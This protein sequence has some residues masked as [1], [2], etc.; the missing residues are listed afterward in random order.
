MSL[1][2]AIAETLETEELRAALPDADADERLLIE[3]VLADRSLDVELDEDGDVIEPVPR[4]NA[5]S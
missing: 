2:L 5:Y 3:S 4:T 1:T